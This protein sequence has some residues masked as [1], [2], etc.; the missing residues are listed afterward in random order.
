M[1][2]LLGLLAAL[3]MMHVL[4]SVSHAINFTNARSRVYVDVN[5]KR[6]ANY[7][8]I[9]SVQIHWGS[10]DDYVALR[11]LGHGKY[12]DTFEAIR[13]RDNQVCALKVLRR[14]MS[15]YRIRREVKALR[16]LREGPN[17]VQLLDV[18]SDDEGLK[19]SF[20]FEYVN[21]TSY[22]RL[23]ESFTDYD[24]RYYI[25]QV[26]KALDYAHSNGI[27]HR[28]IK[29]ENLAIDHQNRKLRVIDWGSGEY[30]RPGKLYSTMVSTPGYRGPELAVGLR[31]YPYDYSLDIWSLG[32]TLADIL[33]QELPFFHGEDRAFQLVWI[34]KVLGTDR[35]FEYL[36]R[37]DIQL[38]PRVTRELKAVAQHQ[39]KPWATFISP[40]N[41][42]L[43]S[44]DAFHLLDRML[45]YDPRERISAREAMDHPYFALVRAQAGAAWAAPSG[46]SVTSTINGSGFG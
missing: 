43:I 19:K 37:Y 20:V 28:D 18:V 44:H 2:S 22:R 12:G 41:K 8:D 31:K 42:G 5:E 30:Y 29:P 3:C 38:N 6:P 1:T 24:V 23:Y 39:R 4:F 33:F 25:F 7:S 34:A 35:L 26:L 27:M 10:R 14:T 32:C 9:H 13:T 36:A 11:F 16:N 21:N 40:R 45:L 46:E 17:I 15:S